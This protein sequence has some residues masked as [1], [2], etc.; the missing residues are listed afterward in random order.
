MMT[1]GANAVASRMAVGEV[2][3]MAMTCLRWVIVVAL[4]GAT[5]GRRVLAE[6]GALRSR[7]RSLALMGA[8]GYTGFNALFYAAAHST[9]AVNI[10]V[11]QGVM[12]VLVLLGSYAIFR[13]PVR[14]LQFIGAGVTIAGVAVM[15]C[16]GDLDVLRTLAFNRGDVWMMV[17][18]VL[19]AGYTVALRDRPAVSP[20]TFFAAMAFSAFV[21]SVPLLGAEIA[22]GQIVWPTPKGWVILVLVALVPSFVSQLLFLRGVQLIG[23]GRAGLFIN[24]IPVFAAL[25]GVVVLGETFAPYHAAALALVLAGIGLAEWGRPDLEQPAA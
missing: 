5:T 10:G 20:Q 14:P 22:L 6:A 13:T 3:P 2:S 21:T 1:W 7:W 16:R 4:L 24:L 17:A 8:L 18:S 15:A 9:T 12:P 23:P 25:G 11:I 19:Y